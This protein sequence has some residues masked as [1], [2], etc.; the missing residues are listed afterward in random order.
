MLLK[1]NPTNTHAWCALK[2]HYDAI[3]DLHMRDL[4]KQDQ[5]RFKKF[6]LRFDDILLDYSKNRITE[7]TIRLLQDL[8][9]ELAVKTAIEKMFQG[10]KIN[11]TENRAVLHVALR[12]RSN[13]PICIDGQDIMPA[14]NQVLNQIE[15]FSRKVIKGIWRGYT[16]KPVRDIVNIGIGGS[17]LGPYMVTEALRPYHKPNLR[18]HFVS[19]VDSSHIQNVLAQVQPETTLFIISSKS[20]TTLETMTNA[21]TARGWFLQHVQDESQIIKHF[22]AVSNNAEKVTEFGIDRQNMFHF[23]DWVGGRYSLWSAIGL[24]VA[25]TIGYDNFTQLLAGAHAMDVHFQ[26]TPLD[27][28]IPVIL[29]LLGIWYNNFFRAESHVIVPYD[30]NLRL[31]PAYL[32]QTD[33]ESNGKNHDRCGEKITYQTGPVVWGAPGTNGQHAFFQLIHQG[34]KLIPGDFIAPTNSHNP[35]GDHHQKLLANFFAQTKALMQGRTAEQA[36]KELQTQ[37]LDKQ[38]IEH[39]LPFKIFEGNKPTNS[40]LLKKITPYTLGSLLAL[41]EHKIFVQGI[42]WNI[43]SFDQWGVEL[44]KKLAKN[45]LP[46]LRDR[47]PTVNHDISTNNLINQYQKWRAE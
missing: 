1:K 32:Q 46:E 39:I 8:A 5:D 7:K 43:Y 30:Q 13:Q 11:E 19:N 25:C 16:D 45:I 24:S 34:T 15:Q 29:A 20:F 26:K 22:V 17:D 35:V 36:R 44:G 9:E 47:E 23:W 41:Y 18:S 27:K 6:S 4:F 3:K 2:N 28:N 14:V 12:N 31:F 10:E 38:A 21:H 33:M 40:I 42:I 37:G